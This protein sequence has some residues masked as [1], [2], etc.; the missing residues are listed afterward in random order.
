VFKRL[1]RFSWLC[2]GHCFLVIGIIGAFLPVLPTVPF[3]LLASACYAK[4]SERFHQKLRNSRWFGK[5]IQAWEAGR[6]ISLRT[7][8]IAVGSLLMSVFFTV[9]FLSSLWLKIGMIVI[10]I[11]VIWFIWTRTTAK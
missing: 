10:A 6:A 2:L 4:G 7:K 8:F 1:K 9:I 5:I 3:I 11:G